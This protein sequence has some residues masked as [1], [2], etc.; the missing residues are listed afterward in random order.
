M[1]RTQLRPPNSRLVTIVE[2]TSFATTVA[3]KN[4]NKM[5]L[6]RT[7]FSCTSPEP[8]FELTQ[9]RRT[10]LLP[11]CHSPGACS[12]YHLHVRYKSESTPERISNKSDVHR[13]GFRYDG[14]ST[15]CAQQKGRGTLQFDKPDKLKKSMLASSECEVQAEQDHSYLSVCGNVR[16]LA[17][18]VR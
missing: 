17:V 18:P 12:V 15:V 14:H 7:A 6:A 3:L 10:C 11:L 5:R 4:K 2:F 8:T 9:H 13:H 16:R 1:C